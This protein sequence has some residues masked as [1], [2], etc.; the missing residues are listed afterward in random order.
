MS[1]PFRDS[2]QKHKEDEEDI[3]DEVD[4]A[5][6]AVGIVNSIVV[7]VPKDDPKLSETDRQGQGFTRV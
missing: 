1:P 4:R 2:Y 6:D 7:K 5:Q 3:G